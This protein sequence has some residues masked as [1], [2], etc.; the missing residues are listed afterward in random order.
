M[1]TKKRSI[2]ESISNVLVGFGVAFLSQRLI[3]PLF[4]IH[5]SVADNLWI[6]LWFTFI[7]IIRSYT[8]RRVFNRK[9]DKKKGK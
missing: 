9:D 3:F 2:I 7:S 1:Q 6:T 8:L 5:I 4:G